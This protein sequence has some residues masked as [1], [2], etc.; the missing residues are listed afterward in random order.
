M[1]G[2][3]YKTPQEEFWAG[4]FGIE[5]ISRNSDE[6][7]IDANYKFFSLMLKKANNINSAIE[8]G[9]NIGLNLIAL[10]HLFPTIELSAI[11]INAK[12]VEILRKQE[13][14]KIYHQ[15]L[16][17]FKPDFPRDFSFTK[18]VLIH[19]NPKILP[20]VYEKIYNSSKKYIGI[21]EYF[22]P[23][24]VTITYREK[25]NRLYKRDFAG[26]M[27]DLFPDLELIDYGFIY[28]RDTK[29]PLEEDFNWFL[30]KK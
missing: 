14:L 13:Y 22:N 15:S 10:K 5:Y 7:N 6:K 11:E 9:S 18:G 30:F 20:M 8:F 16:L 17:C 23:I 4:E 24:P 27:L 1:T 21:V 25:K 28:R 3:K 19:L 26:E 2:Q 29:I 12:A